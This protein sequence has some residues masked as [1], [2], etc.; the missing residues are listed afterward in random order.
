[1]R[2]YTPTEYKGSPQIWSATQDNRGIIYF[3]TG[4]GGGIL[5]YDGIT[6]RTLPNIKQA[7]FYSLKKFRDGRIYV[8]ANRD[9]GYITVNKNGTSKF[10]SLSHILTSKGINIGAVYTVNV[11][12]NFVY[13]QTYEAIFQYAPLQKTVEV[14]KADSGGSFLGDFIY[15]D[16]YYVRMNTKGIVEVENNKLILAPNADCFSKQHGFNTAVPYSANSFLVPTYNHG[17]YIYNLNKDTLPKILPVLDKNFFEDNLIYDAATIRPS[18]FILGSFKMGALLINKQGQPLQQ[19][20]ESNRLQ[21]NNIY[22]I[23]TDNT[24]NIWLCLE[25]GICKTEHSQDMSYW[26]KYAGLHETVISLIRHN[27]TMYVGTSSKVYFIDKKDKLIQV[28]NLPVGQNWCFIEPQET[29]MLLVGTSDGIYEIKDGKAKSIYHGSHA[30]LLYQTKANPNRLISTDYD[31]LISFLYK[32]GRWKFEGRWKGIKE[33]VR[34]IAEEAN[35]DLWLG[36]YD[37]GAIKV[38]PNNELITK[39][40]KIEYYS[41]KEGIPSLRYVTPHN[42][43][44]KVI[45]A[46][47]Q[48]IYI[49][50]NATNHFEPFREFGNEF[51]NGSRDVF[52]IKEM[53]EGKVWISPSDNFKNDFGYLQP[54]SKGNYQWVYAPFRRL[55]TMS[56]ETFYVEPSGVVWIGGNEGLF[57]YDQRKDTKNYNQQF[58]CLIRSVVTRADS[59]VYG[60]NTPDTAQYGHPYSSTLTYKF[61]QLTF[62]FAAPF[63]DQEDKTLYSYKLCGYDKEWSKWGRQTEK[64][65][66]HLFEGTYTFKVK[67]RNVYGVES[68]TA[69]YTFTIQPPYYRTWMA[70]I[71]YVGLFVYGIIFIIK[72][73]TRHLLVQKA[74][75][76]SIIKEKTAEVVHQ[77]EVLQVQ[78]DELEQTNATK[79]RFFNIIAHDLINPFNSLLGFTS[80]L[81]SKLDKYDKEQIKKTVDHIANLSSETYKLLENLLAWSRLQTGKLQPNIKQHNLKTI[82]DE[83]FLLSNEMATNKKLTLRSLVSSTTTVFCDKEMTTTILRNLISNAIK[84]TDPKG[85]ITVLAQKQRA[86]NNNDNSPNTSDGFIEIHV[87]DNGVGIASDKLTS[88]FKL[89]NN[90]S[91]KGTANEKGTGLGLSLCK[92]LTEKQG[93]KIWVESE[94]GIGSRFIFTLTTKTPV[95]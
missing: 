40:K 29:K 6:W 5:E 69:T 20:E 24:Q 88:L 90:T 34:G 31:M 57:R 15:N 18:Y 52:N 81:Q 9:F 74:K 75:L 89:D 26:N 63:F 72:Y 39:P 35:G 42:F 45:W 37:N 83:M 43:N 36:T 33:V 79:D 13:F 84:F 60:G 48:G 86:T 58:N 62:T 4:G 1:M 71:L 53:P 92:E 77:K 76:S 38:I 8:G 73:N 30:F 12:S 85:T 41:T 23:S 19:Y 94:L 7:S 46:T 32:D 11:T 51:C 50:N 27:G 28:K 54:H 16:H 21:S 3:A 44:N 47:E 2:N 91:T 14:F 87:I 70:Y 22:N 55:P 25:N 68:A 82:V 66:S 95:A 56:I 64:E 10:E 49:Y 17:L 61:N 93:G 80:L 78:K 65:Y 67:A 59:L